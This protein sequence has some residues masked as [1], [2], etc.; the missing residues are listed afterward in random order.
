MSRSFEWLKRNKNSKIKLF[1]FPYAGGTSFIYRSWSSIL[2]DNC[3]L[4]AVQLPGREKRIADPMH[5]TMDEVVAELN[6]DMQ[7]LLDSEFIFFG[8]SLGGLIAYELLHLMEQNSSLPSSVLAVSACRTPKD[9]TTMGK[10]AELSDEAF[11]ARMSAYGGTPEI[12]LNDKEMMAFILPRMRADISILES[13][14]YKERN[15]L[16][17]PIIGFC[18]DKDA[19]VSFS[20]FKRW[21]DFS[22]KKFQCEQYTGGHFYISQ[23]YCPVIHQIL[24]FAKES[25]NL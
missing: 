17:S 12:L 7:E 16:K 18:G 8:H 2:P 3:D 24:H 14:Q 10:I 13:Y 22:E 20:Q 9:I 1:C 21:A 6:A 4:I 5:A 11:K 15:P 23:Q 19:Y 25:L